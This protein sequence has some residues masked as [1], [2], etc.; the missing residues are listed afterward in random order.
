MQP[1]KYPQPNNPK[2]AIYP[3][4]E[5]QSCGQNPNYVMGQNLAL[6]QMFG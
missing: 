3:P 6:Q 4:L 1:S 5:Q 2:A